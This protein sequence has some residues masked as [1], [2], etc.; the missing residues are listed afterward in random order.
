[1]KKFGK[2]NINQEINDSQCAICKQ[3][4]ENVDNAYFYL[5]E[6]VGEGKIDG[7]K[8]KVQISGKADDQ[9][10]Y[11]FFKE[12][13]NVNWNFLNLEVKPLDIM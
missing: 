9:E 10:K 2:F 11:T 13:S 5:C 7:Q 6:W 12:G 1:M 3:E 8:G 4:L